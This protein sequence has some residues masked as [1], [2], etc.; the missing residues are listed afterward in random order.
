MYLF[1]FL[2]CLVLVI[3][4]MISSESLTSVPSKGCDLATC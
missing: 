4:I 1:N 3:N 2:S